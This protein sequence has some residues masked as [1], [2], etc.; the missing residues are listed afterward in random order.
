MI[1]GGVEA[2]TL[3]NV[4]READMRQEI[5]VTDVIMAILPGYLDLG[6][7]AESDRCSQISAALQFRATSAFVY[8][9]PADSSPE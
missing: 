3:I 4:A 9:T 1:G 8:E 6:Y 5:Q 2:E 7:D